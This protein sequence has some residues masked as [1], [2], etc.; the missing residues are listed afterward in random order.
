MVLTIDLSNQ[1]ILEVTKGIYK[2]A[3]AMKTEEVS[4]ILL[5][6]VMQVNIFS[7]L[8]SKKLT[9][10]NGVMRITSRAVTFSCEWPI[11]SIIFTTRI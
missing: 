10:V 11:L 3:L 5:V 9:C 7:I 2:D 6:Q 8:K 4:K 1:A